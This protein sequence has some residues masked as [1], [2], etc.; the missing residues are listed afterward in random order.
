MAYI[1]ANQYSLRP[2]SWRATVPDKDLPRIMY[3]LNYVFS[4]IEYKDQDERNYCDYHNWSLISN[5]EQRMV[6]MLALALSPG[7]F[8]GNVFSFRWI[9]SVT[10]AIIIM[11]RVKFVITFW[12]FNSF[13]LLDKNVKLKTSW[14]NMSWM[15]TYYTKR[16][17]Y[18][19]NQQRE[20][21]ESQRRQT[22][23]TWATTARYP[24]TTSHAC[25]ISWKKFKI[26]TKTKPFTFSFKNFCN[27]H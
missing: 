9:F 18:Y 2:T 6:L 3:Y 21:E 11:D 4:A 25:V 8:D 12:L 22:A 5:A 17:A 26:N 27:L 10:V 20:L 16:L 14:H 7:E 1:F 13:L 23:V 24:N 15:Q 19:F